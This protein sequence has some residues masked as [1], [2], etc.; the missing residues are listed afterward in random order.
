MNNPTDEELAM[1]GYLAF[2]SIVGI[3]VLILSGF[4]A[5]LSH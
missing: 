1:I 4:F 2:M 3:T 5:W